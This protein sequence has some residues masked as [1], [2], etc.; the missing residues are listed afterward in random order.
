MKREEWQERRSQRAGAGRARGDGMPDI[1]EVLP[2][3][4]NAPLVPATAR[5]EA[6]R[7]R[8]LDAAEQVFGEVGYYEASISE[9]TRR[10]GVAQGTFYI[11]FHSKLEIFTELVE[12]LGRRLRAATSAAIV[13]VPDRLEAERIGFRA[14]FAFIAE[15]RPI[16][17]IL[18]EAHHVAPEAA[19][20]YY[21]RIS[22]G[23]AR[24]LSSAM[25]AGTVRSYDPE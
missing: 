24:G 9:I 12:Y 23:Y 10:A 22:Q 14:Y 7:R 2:R 4:G 1:D 3:N 6:T 21:R 13:G 19:Y 15:H 20:A 16:F 8:L 17:R 18:R 5:G 11:Y 25:A